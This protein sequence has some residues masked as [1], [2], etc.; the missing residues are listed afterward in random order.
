MIGAITVYCGSSDRARPEYLEAA[1]QMGAAIAR[2]GLRLV[3]GAGSTGLMGSLADGALQAGG[4]VVGV[5]PAM[6]NKSSLA[7][8]RL[9]E[10]VVVDTM[11]QRK[12]HF[13][14]MADAFI[15]LP[16]GFGTYEELFET[17]TWAQIGLHRKPIG[18][19][20]ARCYFDALFALIDHAKAEG[21]I[22]AEHQDLLVHAETPESL[23]DLL[24][25]YQPPPGLERWTARNLELDNG[26][27]L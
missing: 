18:I 24:S 13:V 12:V 17:L 8:D 25:V 1:W 21:M 3:Y 27:P 10:L 19:L 11:H 22:Y 26:T 14:K 7:H 5:I 20:N 6:F 2:R 15:A 23:L 9:S 16:G 4:R